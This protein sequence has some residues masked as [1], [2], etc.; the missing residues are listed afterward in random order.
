MKKVGVRTPT[1]PEQPTTPPPP[2]TPTPSSCRNP[3]ETHHCTLHVQ[4]HTFIHTGTRAQ[5]TFSFCSFLINLL[6]SIGFEE[7][8]LPEQRHLRGIPGLWISGVWTRRKST[9][10]FFSLSGKLAPC[11]CGVEDEKG[12]YMGPSPTKTPATGHFGGWRVGLFNRSVVWCFL[13]FFGVFWMFFGYLLCPFAP[14][15]IFSM[16]CWGLGGG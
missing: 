2:P 9:A 4:Q 13:V 8:S 14:K 15:R 16:V 7:P 11:E 12:L 1:S 5:T 6:F 10:L 3:T